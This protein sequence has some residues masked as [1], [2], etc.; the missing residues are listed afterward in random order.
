[1]KRLYL[2]RHGQ[3]SWNLEGR[4]QGSKNSDLTRLGIEQA[5]K[6]G[7]YFKNIELDRIYSSPLERAYSTAR[8]IAGIKNLNCKLDSR[9]VEM[10][11]GEWEG[12][13]RTKI[14]EIYPDDF[15][16]WIEKPHLANIPSGESIEAAQK[17]IVEFVNDEI[18]Q[19]DESTTLVVSHGT[20]IRLFLLAALSMD[21]EHYYRLKSHNG[22]FNLIEFRDY[23]PVL[24][25]YNSTCHM[26]III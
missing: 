8:I 12:L 17:R 16:A 3:T 15:R 4:T 22:S 11:F 14:K 9:L 1:M 19:S 7:E 20:L 18:I 13:T 23:G 2:V 26:D 10:N 24:V 21:L 6:L 25:K 5:K